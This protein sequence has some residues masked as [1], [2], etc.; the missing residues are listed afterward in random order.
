MECDTSILE[1][2]VLTIP[3][4]T[5]DHDKIEEEMLKKNQKENDGIMELITWKSAKHETP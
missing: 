3:S 1:P 5:S 2:F 4:R